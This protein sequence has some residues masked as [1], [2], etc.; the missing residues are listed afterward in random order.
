V[1]NDRHM[2]P[3]SEQHDSQECVRKLG[4]VLYISIASRAFAL[5]SVPSNGHH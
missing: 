5:H 1:K 2:V 4:R 3:F